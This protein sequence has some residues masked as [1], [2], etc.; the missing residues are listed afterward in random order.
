MRA[1]DFHRR[2]RLGPP[3]KVAGLATMTAVFAALAIVFAGTSLA[4][5]GTFNWNG[6]NGQDACAPGTTG[7]ILWIFNP[8][9]DAVPTSLTVTWSDGTTVT[10]TGDWTNPGN[11]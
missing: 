5:G 8:H 7:T 6:V 9:S 11:R 4:S 2:R 10:Y 1:F 3:H